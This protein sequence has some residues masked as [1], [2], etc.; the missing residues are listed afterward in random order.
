MIRAALL[1]TIRSRVLLIALLGGMAMGCVGCEGEHP[2]CWND[3]GPGGKKYR[4][5]YAD[6]YNKPPVCEPW[7]YRDKVTR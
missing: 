5:C 2:V 3:S 7:T 6:D 4:C 1:A